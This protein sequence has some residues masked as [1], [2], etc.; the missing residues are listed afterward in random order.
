MSDHALPQPSHRGYG[1]DFAKHAANAAG[2]V[3]DLRRAAFE[4]FNAKGFP[5]KRDEEWRYTNL[6]SLAE[7]HHQ[8]ASGYTPG[9]ASQADIAAFVSPALGEGALVFID[10]HFAADLSASAMPEGVR[11]T[12]LQKALAEGEVNDD[13]RRALSDNPNTLMALNSAFVEDGALI[14][15]A[16]D[17]AVE[18]SIH[19]LF[20]S[21]GK[22]AEV[23]HPRLVVSVG[24]GSRA[25]VV[26]TYGSIGGEA[27]GNAAYWQNPRTDFILADNATFEHIKLHREGATATHSAGSTVRCARGSAYRSHT[28]VLSGAL[29]RSDTDVRLEGEGAACALHAVYPIDGRQHADFNT[30]VEHIVPHCTSEQV[31]KGVMDDHATG[32]FSGKVVVREAA[33]KTV[34]EQ[35]N[36]NLLLSKSATANTKPQLEIYADDVKCSHGATIGEL[37]AD[38]L[39]YLRSR[40][41]EAKD[42]KRMLTVAFA[43]DVLAKITHPSIRE[44]VGDLL[45][46]RLT[47]LGASPEDRKR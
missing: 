7:K 39:F 18:Q 16:A 35:Q 37:N 8:L 14:E 12:P 46:H 33:Q 6:S 47:A 17:V 19:V 20:L 23:S 26:E 34:A 29:T 45:H 15:I 28:V 25:C 41:I 13:V 31:Y 1:D 24:K 38:A 43:E 5:S 10:G 4:S 36:R 30:V 44:H 9:A 27:A 2:W 32:V 3:A 21:S 42:A 22:G 11:F 40:G